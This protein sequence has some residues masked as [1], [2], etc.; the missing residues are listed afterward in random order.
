MMVTVRDR[1][2]KQKA[3]GKSLQDVVTAK[4]TADL[5]A[6]WGKGMVNG[7]FFATLVYSTL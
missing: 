5:D 6:I 2:Q 3:A 7:D 1:V 4:P